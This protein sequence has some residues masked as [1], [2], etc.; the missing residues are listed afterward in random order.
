MVKQI[1]PS[2]YIRN[3][4]NKH[5]FILRILE[6][7]EKFVH[8]LM[9]KK[10]FLSIFLVF[11]LFEMNAQ[12]VYWQTISSVGGSHSMSNGLRVNQSI[13]QMSMPGFSSKKN[14]SVLSGYQ[15]PNISI[16]TKD[17]SIN[18]TLTVFPNPSRDVITVRFSE[19]NSGNVKLS[20]I[21]LS[22]REI[23]SSNNSILNKQLSLSL[24]QLSSASY[25][26]KIST[27]N[28]VFY[29]TIIKN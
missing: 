2:I 25:I 10:T 24:E 15:Q 23:L 19:T 29:E 26:L 9:M 11:S 6:I 17:F 8:C 7:E 12:S 22:G 20:V 16:R 13:G 14:I 3:K 1:K 27:K 4:K 21:D 28:R 18:E 5:R